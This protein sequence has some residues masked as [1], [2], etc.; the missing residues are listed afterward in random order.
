MKC[1]YC[2]TEFKLTVSNKKFCCYP[3]SRAWHRL[4]ERDSVPQEKDYYNRETFIVE[5][6]VWK[7]LH[8]V[9]KNG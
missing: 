7:D 8:G 1:L 9:K 6:K 2:G 3:H 5:L 4:K